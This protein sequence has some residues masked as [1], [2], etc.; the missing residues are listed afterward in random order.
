[1]SSDGRTAVFD[2]DGYGNLVKTTDTRTTKVVTSGGASVTY[3]FDGDGNQRSRVD[4][5]GTTTYAMDKLNRETLRTLTDG[6][7]TLLTYTPPRPRR[8]LHRSH[9]PCRLRLRRRR[10]SYFT[11]TY[12]RHN[13]L[14][15]ADTPT[16]VHYCLDAA[17][18]MTGVGA[19]STC[20][21]TRTT[22]AYND[23]SQLISKNGSSTGWSYN[24]AGDETAANPCISAV[25]RN[26]ETWSD[27]NQLTALTAAY[28][29]T[30]NGERTRLGATTFHN[31]P[32]GLAAS[33]TAGT[34][35]GYTRDPQGTLNSMRTGGTSYYYLTDVDGSVL[36]LANTARTR[37]HSPYGQE[38]STPV[39]AVP[40][41]YRFQGTYLDPTGLNKMG[42]R[43][44]DPTLGRFTQTDPSGQETNP[45]TAFGND[46]TNH[47]DPNGT[48]SLGD[49]MGIVLGTAVGVTA[50]V[51]TQNP[52]VAGFLSGCVGGMTASS[53]SSGS[54][55]G[56]LE[57]CVGTALAAQLGAGPAALSSKW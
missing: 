25:A 13:R 9:R 44:Y 1:M 17:G 4:A 11:Y 36:G 21:D 14:T 31:G 42:A 37:T 52:Y 19:L 34:D 26:G 30:D 39:E 40:Q 28:S 33:T 35:T 6:S 45:Y 18:N 3:T 46:P 50:V 15:E 48:F 20:P 16:P 10:A 27:F 47:T 56:D 12:D 49:T 54:T 7:T 38:A 32:E 5:T 23:A 57:P 29:G 2:T 8:H 51:V 24:A 53:M 55:K 43:Y 22:Y 41:P